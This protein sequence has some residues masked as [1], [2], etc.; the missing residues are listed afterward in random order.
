LIGIDQA[1]AR[2]AGD[3]A[4]ELALRG[5]D[6]VHLAI[7]L[8]LGA[9]TTLVTSDYD[10]DTPRASVG[11]TYPCLVRPACAARSS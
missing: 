9:T 7:A 2:H 5:L 4:E 10:S 11:S 1:L 6:A 8:A 3:L